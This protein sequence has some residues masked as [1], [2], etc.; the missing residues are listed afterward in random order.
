LQV[1]LLGS[2]RQKGEIMSIRRR[3]FLALTLGQLTVIAVSTSCG[4]KQVQ[5]KSVA[6]HAIGL[7][8][9]PMFILAERRTTEEF[10]TQVELADIPN[11]GDHPAALASG[12]V[13]V[14]VTPFTTVINAYGNGMPL[15]IIAGSGLNGLYLL[16]QSG[17]IAIGQ[18]KG[19]KI[20]TFR[21]DTLEVSAYDALR[22]AGLTRDD[23][24]MVYFTT[25][26]ELI[27]A[28]AN[29]SVDAMTHVEPY[30]TQAVNNFGAAV[31]SRGEDVWGGTHPDCVLVTNEQTLQTK[32]D[33]LKAIIAG[34]L[35]AEAF[36]E[37]QYEQAV[38]ICVGKYYK[39]SREDILMAG[40]SQPPGIDIR[41]KENFILD[42]SKTLVDLG[43]LSKP[44]N[45][46]LI[47]FSL[48]GEVINEHPDLLAAV[49]VKAK[50]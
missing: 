28:F 23:F 42:R 10:G 26:A 4:G 14:S 13:D 34:M 17:I 37:Q 15:R 48:L 50:Q 38:D 25:G 49:K 43:Y 3:E 12:T 35:R 45:K 36:I 46:Q 40:K 33:S 30:A 27:T 6:A 22:N 24:Q 41:D 29:K 21:A 39:A 31:L 20:G 2:E 5:G 32:R 19:K 9:M 44:V 47:D 18:L 1:K 16:G 8:N 7:C 11:W